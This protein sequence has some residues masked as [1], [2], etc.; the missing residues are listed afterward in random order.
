MIEVSFEHWKYEFS[1]E[2]LQYGSSHFGEGEA[3]KNLRD[4]LYKACD[5]RKAKHITKGSIDFTE[6][7]IIC[8]NES[9]PE[10]AIADPIA[11]LE[12]WNE[13]RSGVRIFPYSGQYSKLSITNQPGKG[14]SPSSIGVVGEIMAGLFG[15]AIISPW[16]LVRV[17]RRWPD[18]IFYTNDGRYA[19]LE[20]KA[21]TSK[22][23]NYS[24]NSLDDVSEA[25]L[26][27]CLLN[28]VRH[29]TIDPFVKIF[30]SFTQIKEIEPNIRL[31][32]TF[33]ELDV[34]DSRR[35]TTKISAPQP[36]IDGLAERAIQKAI[37]QY[38]IEEG[39]GEL[40]GNEINKN[41]IKFLAHQSIETVLNDFKLMSN[42]D[43]NSNDYSCEQL[44]ADIDIERIR[45][46]KSIDK[47][48]RD[49]KIP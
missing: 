40:R 42:H 25:T 39:L 28:A 43:F 31:S 46:E 17:I 30:Y 48:V 20:A 34:P 36:L 9:F 23:K 11:D 1:E 16:I 35:I 13:W 33:L 6:S 26:G 24:V 29:Q 41:K 12:V 37:H 18:F 45:I 5:T 49:F 7:H 38:M 3:K 2:D 47:Q 19:F 32:V 27:E 4:A 22:N 8:A 21:F 10:A 14:S 15:Q 44:T